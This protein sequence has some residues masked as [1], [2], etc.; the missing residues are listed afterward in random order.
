MKKILTLLTITLATCGQAQSTTRTSERVRRQP[1][2]EFFEAVDGIVA[3]L[4][5]GFSDRALGKGPLV[6]LAEQTKRELER[7]QNAKKTRHNKKK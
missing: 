4:E 2:P 6:N 5:K 3:M 1:S 7:I